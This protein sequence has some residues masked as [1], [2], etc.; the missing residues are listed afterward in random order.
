MKVESLPAPLKADQKAAY[1]ERSTVKE[2]N[3]LRLNRTLRLSGHLFE[4]QQYPYLKAFYDR[5]LTSDSQQIT[6]VSRVQ[7]AS[8]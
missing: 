4:V 1:Y 3:G 6:L 2:G 7:D 5:M 8:K